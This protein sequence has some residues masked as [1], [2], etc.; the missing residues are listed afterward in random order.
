MSN[1]GTRRNANRA[2]SDSTNPTPMVTVSTPVASA[3]AAAKGGSFSI[4]STASVSNTAKSRSFIEAPCKMTASGGYYDLIMLASSPLFAVSALITKALTKR[5]KT[6]VI[7]VWQCITIGFFTLPLA[8]PGW[9]WPT[10]IQWLLFLASGILGSIGHYCITSAL[11]AAD[12]T[13]TQSV[14]FL[15]LIWMSS[16][17]FLVFGDIPTISTVIGGLVIVAATTWIARREAR[18]RV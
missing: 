17:G 18:R 7:V 14:K 6:E 12:A 8:I 16:L 10:L 3:P 2:S 1:N 13:A 15:D 11:R 5:D 9:E 4:G